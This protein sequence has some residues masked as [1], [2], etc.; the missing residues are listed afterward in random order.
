VIDKGMY[1]VLVGR[2]AADAEANALLTPPLVG[3]FIVE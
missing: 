1:T 2:N 3:T